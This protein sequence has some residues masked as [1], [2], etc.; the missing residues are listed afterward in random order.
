M[1][2]TDMFVV[3]P[4]GFLIG[5]FK[6]TPA[7][8]REGTTLDGSPASKPDLLIDL[9]PNTPD[10][11]TA[12]MEEI[13]GNVI[14]VQDQSQQQMFGRKATRSEPVCL[15]TCERDRTYGVFRKSFPHSFVPSLRP[16]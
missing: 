7:L 14:V 2:R 10:G 13:G 11:D 9:T 3:Q 12:T 15:F 5:E 8:R 6:Y 16:R 1:F 4:E